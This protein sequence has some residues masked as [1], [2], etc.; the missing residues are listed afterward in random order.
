[1]SGVSMYAEPAEYAD[2]QV[3]IG[4]GEDDH[5]EFRVVLIVGKC[6][7]DLTTDECRQVQWA[8]LDAMEV[9]DA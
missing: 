7:V 5:G 3:H 6:G 2:G 9:S 8:L 1:M 4:A